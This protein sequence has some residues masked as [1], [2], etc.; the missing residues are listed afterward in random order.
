MEI[1][2]TCI[3]YITV[4]HFTA[5]HHIYLVIFIRIQKSRL[6]PVKHSSPLNN[7]YGTQQELTKFLY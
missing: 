3:H 1:I 6:T 4:N 2:V 5:T 7:I